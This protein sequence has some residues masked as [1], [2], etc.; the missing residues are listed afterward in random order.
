M[1][2]RLRWSPERFSLGS[3]WARQDA[4][5]TRFEHVVEVPEDLLAIPT[6]LPREGMETA[7]EL[8]L[9]PLPSLSAD[10]TVVTGRDLLEPEEAVTDPAV[11]ALLEAERGGPL[12][13]DL[14]WETRRDVRTRVSYRPQL[15]G[16]L[17][18]DLTWSTRY[19]SDRNASLV[20]RWEE[21]GDTLLELQ[22][23]ADGQ[24]DLRLSLALDP[25]RLSEAVLGAGSEDLLP[26]LLAR[27]RPLTVV[28]QDGVVARFHRE[29]VDPGT[30]F[31][32]GWGDVDEF[33]IIDGDTAAYLTDRRAWTV[34]S[35]LA[36]GSLS[37]DLGWSR[38]RART[39]DARSERRI[40]T[41][42]WPDLR[43]SLRDLSLP[44]GVRAVV[45]SG[46]QRLR[47]ETAFGASGG[48]RRTDED[49]QV[50][51]EVTFAWARDASLGYRG[52]F[53]TGAGRDPTGET[54]RDR[55][56]H[57]VSLATSV[58][59]P[60][61]LPLDIQR[62]LRIAVI[63]GYSADRDCRQVAGGLSCVSFVD[64]V[65]QSLSVSLDTRVSGLEMGLNASYLN[66]Q[67]HVG[68][69]TGSTQLQI[70]LFGQFLFEAGELP[71]RA[72]P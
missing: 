39:W 52:A 28:R 31:Q 72:V 24:R 18:H 47:R 15:F 37:A 55:G 19:V 35:G 44:F 30:R 1:A 34:G 9:T 32:L 41:H 63:W 46:L 7:G 21:A 11:Q 17:R 26:L 58:V 29:P 36:A 51:A 66:R 48:Q 53:R 43:V 67:S 70:G 22:R 6:R 2:A 3:S 4:R 8:R 23:S 65:N 10:L 49:L 38:T 68:Q 59:A 56:S 50:P 40:R 45:S 42:S 60:L 62:P 25:A 69:R 71:L 13:L 20:R 5:L 61:W 16:W 64:Q 54:E 27:L 12:G 33:R 57:R 14:G